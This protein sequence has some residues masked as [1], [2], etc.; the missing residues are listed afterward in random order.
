MAV[1]YHARSNTWQRIGLEQYDGILLHWHSSWFTEWCLHNSPQV[2]RTRTYQEHGESGSKK[3]TECKHK[4][5]APRY[6]KVCRLGWAV[7]SLKSS[8]SVRYVHSI[9][10]RWDILPELVY[11]YGIPPLKCVCTCEGTLEKRILDTRPLTLI[12][13]EVQ[14]GNSFCEEDAV[15]GPWWSRRR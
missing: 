6:I 9:F 5:T 13:L 14:Q 1:L 4:L 8:E 11:G 15:S 7:S 3:E 12:M 10:A 2:I